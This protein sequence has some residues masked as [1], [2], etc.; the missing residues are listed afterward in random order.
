MIVWYENLFTRNI[1]ERREIEGE[2]LDES[3]IETPN[4]DMAIEVS[5]NYKEKT[6]KGGKFLL[7]QNPFHPHKLSDFFLHPQKSWKNYNLRRY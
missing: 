3:G 5:T 6:K 1:E 4:N 7:L 2:T